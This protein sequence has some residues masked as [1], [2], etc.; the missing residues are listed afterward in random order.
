MVQNSLLDLVESEVSLI[1]NR[2][3]VRNIEIVL[4]PLCPRKPDDPIEVGA[5]DGRFGSHRVQFFQ[6]P[7]FALRPLECMLG[8]VRG[9]HFSR[10]IRPFVAWIGAQLRVDRFELL[11][12]VEL[13]A[14]R[15]HLHPDLRVE[16]L[17]D[18]QNLEFAK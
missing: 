1:E 8:K 3:G 11:L 12:Q 2:C 14:I 4:P 15:I 10:Q 5:N 7:E 17:L 13:S 9:N 16:L 6:T 18:A